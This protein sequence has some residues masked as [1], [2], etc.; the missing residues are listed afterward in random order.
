MKKAPAVLLL[1]GVGW[2]VFYSASF[3]NVGEFGS[4]SSPAVRMSSPGSRPMGPTPGVRMDR[5]LCSSGADRVRGM[6]TALLPRR[7][8]TSSSV[9]SSVGSSRARSGA[10]FWAGLALHPEGTRSGNCSRFHS[11]IPQY[12]G[13]HQRLDHDDGGSVRSTRVRAVTDHPG[14]LGWLSVVFLVEQAIET[15]TV[16]GSTGFLAPG[17][18]MNLYLGGAIGL[19]TGSSGCWSGATS[20]RDRR[21]RSRS[22][23]DRCGGRVQDPPPETSVAPAGPE[24]PLTDDV[25][26]DLRGAAT[27]GEGPTEQESPVPRIGLGGF[28]VTDPEHSVGSGGLIISSSMAG[29]RIGPRLADRCVR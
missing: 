20:G 25:A 7:I 26:L 14:W 10:W 13:D 18:T 19:G 28:F 17:G 15:I 21:V 12:W 6:V 3:R 16:F 1:S 5:G 29:I 27:D 22:C 24:E 9:E 8:G 23:V 4:R 11:A 2:I